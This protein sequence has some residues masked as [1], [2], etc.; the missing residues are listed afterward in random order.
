MSLFAGVETEEGYAASLLQQMLWPK[1]TSGNDLNGLGET[2]VRR[3]TEAFHKHHPFYAFGPVELLF[4]ID[5]MLDAVQR[6]WYGRHW[7]REH[8]TGHDAIA[9]NKV[10]DTAEPGWD[11]SVNT[12]P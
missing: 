2:D 12:V 4:I 10:E 9:G 5:S 6:K 11:N 3:P 7:K 1:R 8:I